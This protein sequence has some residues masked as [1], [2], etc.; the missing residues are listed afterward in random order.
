MIHSVEGTSFASQV[1]CEL[2]NRNITQ[3]VSFCRAKTQHNETIKTLERE[4]PETAH[5]TTT[6]W[7][8]VQTSRTSTTK[9]Q[10][11]H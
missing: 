2:A 5:N 4:T 8:K 11:Q 10:L 6:K 1:E 7:Q 3:S 9:W